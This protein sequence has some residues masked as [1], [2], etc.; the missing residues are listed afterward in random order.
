M[1]F[2]LLRESLTGFSSLCSSLLASWI[3]A[4]LR[5]MTSSVSATQAAGPPPALDTDDRVNGELV[6]KK[7]HYDKISVND[8]GAIRILK[9]HCASSEH[10]DVVCEL[11][12]GTILD[13]NDCKNHNP[14]LEFKPYDALSWCWG[15]GPQDGKI[16]IRLEG[17]SYVKCVQASVV[18]A[19]RAFRHKNS[20]RH[21]WVDAICINQDYKPEKN[22]Q[23]EM[24]A[25]IYGRA[26][27]VRIWLGDLDNSS[28][29]AIL[30]IKQQVL[31]LQHFDD[32]CRS[33]EFSEKWK[34]LLELM[35]REWFSRRWVVQEVALAP[36]AIIH[37]GPA[38]LSWSKFAVAV[39]L[40]VEAETATHRLS[41]VRANA[42][43]LTIGLDGF[44]G[45]YRLETSFQPILI[46]PW[47][48]CH[49]HNFL[50]HKRS[51]PTAR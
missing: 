28:K 7:I 47:L 21:I 12:S 10:D 2:S 18:S 3:L 16:N 46:N 39:E 11:I 15:K 23:V 17:V 6:F 5:K 36:K 14:P 30:F 22:R 48:H 1:L 26:D 40:F 38:K 43:Y 32:L 31:Q 25:D 41:E 45:K 34:S 4:V 49:F 13:Y 19:L 8:R 27:C 24:M 29:L 42:I 35:Q 20:D 33:S 51:F 9:V 44:C 37:C 50:P